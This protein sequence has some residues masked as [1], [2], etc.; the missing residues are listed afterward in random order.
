VAEH[1]EQQAR[2]PQADGNV[3]HGRM[4]GMTERL[5]VKS[6]GVVYDGDSSLMMVRR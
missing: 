4:Q 6:L 5:P 2:A 1:I 3:G